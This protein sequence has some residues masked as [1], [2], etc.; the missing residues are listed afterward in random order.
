[1]KTRHLL[2]ACVLPVLFAACKK[3]SNDKPATPAMADNTVAFTLDGKSYT[4][5]GLQLSTA[6][7]QDQEED[8]MDSLY[9]LTGITSNTAI[10]G[11]L[12]LS[13]TFRKGQV[14]VGN[15]GD[16]A[17]AT[18]GV[19]WVPALGGE[20]FYQSNSSHYSTI[21]VTHADGQVLEGT[22]SGEI[23]STVD[24]DRVLKLTGGK[25]RINLATV[26]KGN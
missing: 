25:F 5:S 26:A 2:M 4:T 19:D 3:D 6:S 16:T 18:D 23:A 8:H 15:Y 11:Q 10:A 12:T 9:V 1:M 22:F 17:Y 14:T 7:V 24:Q 20:D 21:Q 13:I